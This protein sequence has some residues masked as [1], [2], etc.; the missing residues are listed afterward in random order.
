MFPSKSAK[1]FVIVILLTSGFSACQWWKKLTGA[2]SPIPTPFIAREIPVDLP[3]QN[4]EPENYQAEFVISIFAGDAKTIQKT[5]IAR[6][7]TKYFITF[8]AGE[9]SAFSSLKTG[10]ADYFL[11]SDEKKVFTEQIAAANVGDNSEN[12]LEDFLT[13]EW[14]NEKTAADFEKLETEN[15]LTKFRVNLADSRNSE[16]LIYFDENLKIPVRQEFY[17]ARG[18]RKTLM[19]TAEI[20]NFKSPA[21]VKYF[22]LPADYRKVSPPEFDKIIR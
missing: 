6:N 9:K 18:E 10:A 7:G 2:P 14:L 8:N 22:E 17:S 21:D 5:F 13:T 20:L 1:I 3:F 19:L 12:F 15:N 16:I 4:K 11:I